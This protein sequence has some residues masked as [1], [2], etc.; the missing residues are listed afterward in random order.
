M[1]TRHKCFTLVLAAALGAPDVAG[2]REPG[3]NYLEAGI[4]GGFVN[5]VERSERFTGNLGTLDVETDADAGGFFGASWQFAGNVHLFGD[6]WAGGQELE[7]RDGGATVTGEFDVVRWRVGV[8]YSHAYSNALAFY[9]RLSF[10]TLEFKDARVAGF[11]VDIEADEDGV[12]GEVGVV[13]APS[14]AWHL[15]GHVRYTPVGKV[16]DSGADAFDS[17]VLVGINGRWYFRPNLALV[18]GYELGKI[19][20][21]NA[22]LRLAF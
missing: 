18:A 16:A 5:D 19:T 4:A 8:G 12:G 22:G 11:D 21:L 10:D 9:G 3:F 15:Q 6:Y 17:D 14:P 13:W 7:I 1:S 2:A 20:T